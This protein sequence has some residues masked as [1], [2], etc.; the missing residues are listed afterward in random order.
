[1]KTIRF[2][3]QSK[4][5]IFL[6]L[7]LALAVTGCAAAPAAQTQSA[8]SQAEVTSE[9]APAASEESAAPA[10]ESAAPTEESAEET[11]L[12]SLRIGSLKGPTS[13]GIADLHSRAESGEAEG[14][15][16][17]VME[18]EPAALAAALAG[19]DIDIALLPANLA[20]ILYQKTQGAVAVAN[21]NTLG[22]L[23]CVTGE[24]E[25]DSPE[26]LAGRTVLL[27]GQG[28]TPEYALRTI[29][30]QYA[31]EDVTLE[32]RSEATEVAALLREDASQIAILPQPFATAVLMQNEALHEA[33]SL[34]EAWA[35]MGD[36]SRLVTGVTLVRKS[37]A[38]EAP[39]AVALFLE[40]QKNSVEAVLSDPQ[41][42]ATQI[43]AQGILENE[44][45]AAK[46]LPACA[47]TYM[48]GEEMKE[49]LSGYLETLWEQDAQAVGGAL[50]DE[51]FYGL[52]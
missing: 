38:E 45:M 42:A 1:M 37:V 36:G 41:K 51:D 25:I 3:N 50:P 39:E 31:V 33:F 44:A 34:E 6:A 23:Y 48:D 14:D 11:A 20:A 28:A 9:N 22:V 18:T 26:D 29:L 47:L 27:T 30:E 43:V 16:S 24:E 2:R 46:A 8:P 17:F 15:Y 19:G 13:M 12:A 35:A 7:C 40:E 52:P 32:F 10:E 4:M 21:I 5:K 49:A